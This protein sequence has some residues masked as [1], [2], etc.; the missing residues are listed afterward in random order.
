MDLSLT[1]V[2]FTLFTVALCG[3][4]HAADKQ[5]AVIEGTRTA[6]KEIAAILSSIPATT[7][8]DKTL[9]DRL[10]RL[11]LDVQSVS[12][13]R[14]T[15][16]DIQQSG[17]VL[18]RGDV[19]YLF[20]TSEPSDRVKAECAVWNTFAFHRRGHLWLP[21]TKTANYLMNGPGHCKVP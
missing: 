10:L 8:D 17:G 14:F 12:V 11:N 4:V 21:K 16:D 9:A 18:R 13:G 2:R 7:P 20:R 15:S 3:A 6:P 19:N 5:P 1:V